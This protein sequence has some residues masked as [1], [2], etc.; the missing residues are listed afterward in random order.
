MISCFILIELDKSLSLDSFI[1]ST[2][3]NRSELEDKSYICLEN[4]SKIPTLSSR[5]NF[6]LFICNTWTSLVDDST[7]FYFLNKDLMQEYLSIFQIFNSSLIEFI[8]NSNMSQI[9][10][11][12]LKLINRG[13]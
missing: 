2:G 13:T 11:K 5:C 4:Y 3:Y 6:D 8:E 7:S 9:T 12:D 1:E 10:F